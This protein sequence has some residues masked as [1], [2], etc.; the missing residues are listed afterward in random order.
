MRYEKQMIW[1][2]K[3]KE[4][5]SRHQGGTELLIASRFRLTDVDGVAFT[6]YKQTNVKNDMDGWLV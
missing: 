5:V 6:Y 1:K 4:D 2:G 3:F